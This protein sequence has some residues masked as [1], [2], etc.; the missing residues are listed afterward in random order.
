MATPLTPFK[1]Y[2]RLPSKE[3]NKKS[4]C[5]KADP[6]IKKHKINIKEPAAKME[7]LMLSHQP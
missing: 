3:P 4:P 5:Y 2:C 1:K 7:I 6:K